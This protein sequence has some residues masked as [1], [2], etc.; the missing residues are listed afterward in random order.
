MFT[1]KLSGDTELKLLQLQNADEL[2]TLVEN[3]REHLRAWLP[4]VDKTL[5]VSDIETFI[6]RSLRQYAEEGTITAGIFVSG[7]LVGV[8]SLTVRDPGRHEIG[9]WL[10]KDHQGSGIMTIACKALIEFAFHHTTAQRIDIRVEPTN[11][12]SR[13]IPERLGFTCESVYREPV[14]HTND[15]GRELVTYVMPKEAWLRSRAI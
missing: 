12:R 1:L 10:D 8:I 15:P 14:L 6:N 5:S 9:Y 13:A 4:W 2:Y 3:N 7:Y 11:D